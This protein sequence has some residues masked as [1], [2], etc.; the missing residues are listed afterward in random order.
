MWYNPIMVKIIGND[1]WR[2]GEKVGWIE[3]DY[4][5]DRDGKK[6][7]YFQDKYVYDMDARKIAYIEEDSLISQG[8]GSEA[9][10]H[11]DQVAE[12]VEGGVLPEI[13][14]CAVYV[15]LGD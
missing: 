4:V 6:L 15:L 14:K 5:R 10:I 11:L 7:G 13:G 9:K 1:I 2:G 12:N 3:G 8:S